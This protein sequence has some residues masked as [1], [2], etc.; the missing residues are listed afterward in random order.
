MTVTDAPAASAMGP[1]V[2]TKNWFHKAVRPRNTKRVTGH[3]IT[4]NITA[5]K[6]PVKLFVKYL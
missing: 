3:I 2:R 6:T 4:E 1:W 5:D